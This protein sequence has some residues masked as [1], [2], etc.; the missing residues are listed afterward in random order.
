[1]DYNALK[2]LVINSIDSEKQKA[3]SLSDYISENPELSHKEFLACKKYVDILR[4]EGIFV[5]EKFLGKDTAFKATIHEDKDPQIKIGILAEYDAL[6]EIDH[7]CGHSA[8]GALSFLAALGLYKNKEYIKGNIYLIGI[9]GE[10]N[11]GFKTDMAN[12]G[13][14]DDFSFVIMIHMSDKSQAYTKF[15][16]LSAC[17]Y[18]FFGSPAH[19]AA[20]PWSG[21]NA[22]N[23][24][25]LF[26][27][28]LDMMRQ[29]LKDG[30]R[31]HGMIMRGGAAPN[32][33]PEYVSCQYWFRYS[34]K[35]YLDEV[36]KMAQDAAEGCAM[37]TGTKVSITP[38]GRMLADLKATPHTDAI[39]ESIY[40][41]LGVKVDK[42]PAIPLGSSDI[43]NLSYRCPAFHPV[44]AVSETPV[45]IHTNEFAACMLGDKTKWAIEKGAKTIAIIILRS[46]YDETIIEN[47]KKD[48]NGL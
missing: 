23:G 31:I 30:T 9:P 35:K 33:I 13:L 22:M 37:A 21:K 4:E 8:S 20:S 11:N 25:T 40:E 32:I 27:H 48:F 1:M 24:M 36:V 42:S 5:E 15:M 6:P 44:I 29:Q 18:E 3:F 43:G 34:K 46:F 10:E 12:S 2:D 47:M 28:A 14:F 38:A 17:D 16:A 7:A 26:I 41:E 45:A 39:I 19:A